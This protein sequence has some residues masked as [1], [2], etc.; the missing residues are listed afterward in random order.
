MFR[1]PRNWY[2]SNSTTYTEAFALE[3]LYNIGVFAAPVLALFF[4]CLVVKICLARRKA[5]EQLKESILTSE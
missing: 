1:L 5:N 4:I 2:D 3:F